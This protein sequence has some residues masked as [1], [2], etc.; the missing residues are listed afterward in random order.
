LAAGSTAIGV[1]LDGDRGWWLVTAGVPDSDSPTLPSFRA[2]M[3]FAR[4]LQPGPVMLSARAIDGAG[5]FGPASQLSLTVADQPLPPGRL[6]VALSWAQASDLDVHVVEPGGFEIW[7]DA[8]MSPS[9]GALDLDSNSQCLID[10]HDREVVSWAD[11]PS[12][13]YLVRVDSFS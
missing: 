10:G 2:R 12:G 5:R 4:T 3:S 11:P 6:T 1:Q 7:S 13:H 9:G 8:P